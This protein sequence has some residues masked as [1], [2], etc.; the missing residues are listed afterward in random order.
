MA[1][2]DASL[3]HVANVDPKVSADQRGH[4]IGVSIDVYTQSNMQQKGMAAKALEDSVLGVM[5]IE[6]GAGFARALN[7]VQKSARF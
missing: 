7:V 2:V 4:G 5:P 6:K 3:S 1:A